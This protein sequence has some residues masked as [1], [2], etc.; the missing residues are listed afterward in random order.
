MRF[1]LMGILILG[2]SHHSLKYKYNSSKRYLASLTNEASVVSKIEVELKHPEVF[3]SGMDSTYLFAKLFDSEGNLLTDVDPNDL[4]LSSNIDIEA[5]PFVYKQGVYRSQILPRVRS[6][7]IVLRVD[8]LEKVASPEISLKTRLGPKKDALDPIVHDYWETKSEGEISLSRGSSTPQESTESF[9]FDNLGGNKI[10][11]GHSSKVAQR[12]FSFDYNEQA[13]QNLSMMVDDISGTR[14]SQAMHSIF[15]FFPRKNLFLVE[16]LSGTVDVTLPTGEKVSFQKD[17]KEIVSGVL[18]EG[19]LGPHFPDLRYTGKGII[20]RANARGESPEL[21]EG[22]GKID[23]EHGLKGSEDALL[24]N[25]ATGQKCRRPKTDFW[26]ALDVIPIEFK[27]ATDEAFDKYLK[28]NC[29]FGL[30][31]SEDLPAPMKPSQNK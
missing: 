28:E 12:N 4:T 21:G 31:K 30:F 10:V 27:F 6:P 13:R 29:G 8:W 20:L 9:S 7:K 22:E 24:I 25:G 11:R 26:D 23:L 17:S 16:Q 15:M 18:T 3:A 19:P 14:V 1:L 2:C 5:K